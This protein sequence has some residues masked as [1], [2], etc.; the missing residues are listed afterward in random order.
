MLWLQVLGTAAAFSP[1]PL[2]LERAHTR[3]GASRP[4]LLSLAELPPSGTKV[5]EFL[6][7]MGKCYCAAG[8]A[9]AADFASG[10][11][12]PAAAGLGPF[13]SL[14]MEGQALGVF[15]V[16]IGV[17]QPLASTRA[18]QQAL[19]AAYG[20]YEIILTLAASTATSDPDGNLMRLGAAAGLQLIVGFC[21][22]ELR[23]QSLE[24]AAAEKKTSV[25][26]RR[27][28]IGA[29]PRMMASE[30]PAAKMRRG[31]KEPPPLSFQ[32][33][34]EEKLGKDN[35]QAIVVLTGVM[36]YPLMAFGA[37]MKNGPM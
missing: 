31:G 9:H 15:W 28:R 24:A 35:F 7:L 5:D 33:K 19:V 11:A 22:Y 29:A 18:A 37:I 26:G 13:A 34:L 12:L 32:Q 10:N 30:R 3:R 16:L 20:A 2:A 4:S 36:C 23:K 6:S 1:G 27:Q 21:Y 25:A 8:I 14:P 17:I